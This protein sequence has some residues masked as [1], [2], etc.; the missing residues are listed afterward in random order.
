[1]LMATVTVTVT[2]TVL[3]AVLAVAEGGGGVLEA[4]PLLKLT[5]VLEM[6]GGAIMQH[7]YCN[8]YSAVH[9][10]QYNTCSAVL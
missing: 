10:V 5:A 6:I 1:M 3:L 2:V 4:L 8:T 9:A 7:L